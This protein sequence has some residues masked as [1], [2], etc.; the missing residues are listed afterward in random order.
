[1]KKTVKEWLETIEY[2]EIKAKAFANTKPYLLDLLE[3]SLE[4]SLG[5][6]F[7]WEYTPEGYKFWSDFEITLKTK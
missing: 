3:D 7:L 4:S 6:A 5:I 1:M 2:P